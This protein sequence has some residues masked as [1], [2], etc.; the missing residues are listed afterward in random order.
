MAITSFREVLP[1]TFQHRFGEAPT[2]ERKFVATVD[3]PTPTQQVLNAIG[4]FHGSLHP[5]YPYLRCLNGAFSEP[6]RFHVEATYSYELPS[7]G[8]QDLDPNPLARRDVWSFSTGGAQVPA[9]YYYAGDALAPLVN[10]AGDL[11]EGL[12]TTEAEMRATISGNRPV[13]DYSLAASVTNCINDGPYL[14]GAPCTWMCTGITG[15]QQ[16][17]VVNDVEIKYWSFTTELVYRES[18]HLLLLPDV[19]FNYIA[20]SATDDTATEDGAGADATGPELGGLPV[21]PGVSLLYKKNARTAG[22][23]KKR[24]WVL[25][26]ESGDKVASSNVVAL[27]PNGSMKPAGASPNILVRRVHRAINFSQFFGVPYF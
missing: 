4:I 8:T 2:A 14:G 24:A 16:V 1:R 25:D 7:V 18:T 22:G 15:Q 19:G 5:E 10:S 9:L 6:D 21:Q 20:T 13:F 11:F 23:V 12:T 17:E 26:P 3:G 27:N